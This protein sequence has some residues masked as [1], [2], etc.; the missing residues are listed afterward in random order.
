[1]LKNIMHKALVIILFV[2]PLASLYAQQSHTLYFM[3]NVPE[4]NLLNPAVQNECKLF[5]GLPVV[6]SLHVNLANSGFTMNQLLINEAPGE[7]SIDASNIAKKLGRRNYLSTEAYINLFGFGIRIKNRYY[8]TFNIRER[9]DFNLFYTKNLFSLAYKG[10]TQYEGGW[11]SLK[12]NG[13]QFNHYRE[14]SLGISKVVDNYRTF[15]IR[16]KLLFGKLNFKTSRDNV[17]MFTENNTFDLFFNSDAR[18][19]ASL[20][21]S[22]DTVNGNLRVNDQYYPD[23]PVQ[24]LFNSSNIGFAV[25]AGLIYRYDEK[26]TFQASLLDL[27]FIK[28]LTNQTN[29]TVQGELLYT[30]P[31]GDTIITRN[32]AWDLFDRINDSMSVSLSREP[33]TYYL[34]PRLYLGVSYR[35]N[36]T[37]TGNVLIGS[38]IMK[39]KLQSGITISGIWR[40][41]NHVAA[42]FSWSFIHR[43]INN[44]GAGLALGRSPVQFY[45][46]SDNVMGFIWPQSTKNI[47]LR[48][49]LNIILGCREKFNINNCGCYWLQKAEERQERRKK[50]FRK[51]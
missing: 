39:Q 22:L 37:L 40:P 5:I 35:I 38:R 47:N 9:E 6:S 14:Y 7:Y 26:I 42:T 27:G 16:T 1:M 21:L 45:I 3:N 2:I 48:L 20:P 24:I 18:I 34:S 30:G 33:Y 29:Y 25:D 11:L 36:R 50:R 8:I 28:Y 32:Y 41:Y 31:L 17:D 12:G 15:G 44:I 43:S 49:G 13:L 46:V 19:D 23:D 10:N 4:T 51:K